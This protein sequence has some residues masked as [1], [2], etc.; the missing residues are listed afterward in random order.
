MSSKVSSAGRNNIVTYLAVAKLKLDA[1]FARLYKVLPS[2]SEK[3]SEANVKKWVR[4]VGRSSA[5]LNQ[6][7]EELLKHLAGEKS[8]WPKCTDPPC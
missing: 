8:G 3:S 5:T 2:S 6:R 4:D 1:D 7:M